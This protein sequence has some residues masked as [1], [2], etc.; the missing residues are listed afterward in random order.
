MPPVVVGVG[1]ALTTKGTCGYSSQTAGLLAGGEQNNF[2]KSTRRDVPRWLPIRKS[3]ELS[4][5]ISFC[6]V[7]RLAN[8]MSRYAGGVSIKLNLPWPHLRNIVLLLAHNICD[9]MGRG[10]KSCLSNNLMRLLRISPLFIQLTRPVGHI[11]P[12]LAYSQPR[13]GTGA[14]ITSALRVRMQLLSVGSRI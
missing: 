2:L 11:E 6:S 13:Y 3:L 7:S 1:V 5:K 14:Q 9:C 4:V 10:L 12:T 8:Y